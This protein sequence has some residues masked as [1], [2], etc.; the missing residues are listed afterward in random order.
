MVFGV[1]QVEPWS[2]ASAWKRRQDEKRKRK[3]G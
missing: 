2:L 3:Q 1:C